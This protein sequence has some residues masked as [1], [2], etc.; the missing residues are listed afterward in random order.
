MVLI[1]MRKLHHL[2]LRL[3]IVSQ[4]LISTGT[5]WE[6]VRYDHP[7]DVT[8]YSV[9]I[10]PHIDQETPPGF[11]DISA[12]SEVFNA[13]VDNVAVAVVGVEHDELRQRLDDFRGELV[14]E[15]CFFE[16]FGDICHCLVLGWGE[17]KGGD[18]HRW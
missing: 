7:D 1:S 11:A 3:N 14:L 6:L 16:F 9:N 12:V 5:N 4:W 2:N 8:V 13:H 10:W 15:D 17:R 18:V